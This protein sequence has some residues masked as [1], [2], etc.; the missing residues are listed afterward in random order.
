[1]KTVFK[2]SS[3]S[4]L[5][6]ASMANAFADPALY[7]ERREQTPLIQIQQVLQPREHGERQMQRTDRHRANEFGGNGQGAQGNAAPDESRKPGRMTPEERRALRRQINEAGRD[8][9]TPAR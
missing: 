6:M 5:L 3:I 9:Y 7:R 1:M 2:I 8:I 4:L